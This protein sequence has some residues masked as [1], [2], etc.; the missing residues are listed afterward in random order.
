LSSTTGSPV[1]ATPSTPTTYT[2]TVTNLAGCSDTETILVG[3]GAFP[4]TPVMSA[5]PSTVCPGSDAQL[6]AQIGSTPSY[7]TATAT[8]P[9]SC[10]GDEF[11]SN[12]TFG[13]I[14]NPSGCT[15]GSPAFSYN[16]F[17]AQSTTV[18]AGSLGNVLTAGITNLF[19]GDQMRVWFDWNQDGDF[20]DLGEEYLPSGAVAATTTFSIDVPAGAVNG[21]TRMRVRL[22]WTGVIPACG[23]AAYGEIEDYTV[24]VTGG[25][26][27][28]AP[29]INFSWSP[30]TFLS[31]PLIC[32]PVATAVTAATTYTVTATNAS[33]CFS[34]NTVSLARGNRWIRMVTARR[35][36][37]TVALPIRTRS[38][39]AS[40]AAVWLI[41]IRTATVRLIATMAALPIRTRSQQASAAAVWPIRIRTATDG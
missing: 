39:L 34:T 30:T 11:L 38:L 31:D 25:A 2:V 9:T 16:N 28:C 23:G 32:N 40:A 4:A 29:G 20:T 26:S 12:V 7:C 22:T 3:S 17:T 19:S 6:A 36:A 1:T 18:V 8:T 13:S 10:S 14:S 5:T 41:R 35:I 27:S 33:G 37:P 24:V 21:S 15:Y